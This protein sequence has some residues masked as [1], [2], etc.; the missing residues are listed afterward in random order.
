MDEVFMWHAVGLPAPRLFRNLVG[1]KLGWRPPCGRGR[2]PQI[3]FKRS[4]IHRRSSWRSW[5]W[6]ELGRWKG[7]ESG[8]QFPSIYKARSM[9]VYDSHD[10]NHVR[11]HY[12]LNLSRWYRQLPIA[13]DV[14]MA[15]STLCCFPMLFWQTWIHWT[16]PQGIGATTWIMIW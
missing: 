4:L 5:G 8:W 12:L 7:N 13:R 16:Q 9:I 6:G 2:T 10:K 3:D 1:V 11:L 14:P 15:G